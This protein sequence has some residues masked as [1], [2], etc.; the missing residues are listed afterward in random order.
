[1]KKGILFTAVILL[2]TVSIAQEQE[3]ELHGSIDVTYLSAYMWRGIDLYPGA[4]GEGAIQPSISLDLYGTGLGLSIVYSIIHQSGGHV[5]V[6]SKVGQGTTFR[7][8]LP[9]VES[10]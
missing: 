9:R 4:H 7:I 2:S 1:M 6:E 5:E 3:G 8:Y 10:E